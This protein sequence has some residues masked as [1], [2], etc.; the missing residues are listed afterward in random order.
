MEASADLIEKFRFLGVTEPEGWAASQEGEGIPQL[1]RAT[2]LVELA[3]IIGDTTK[4]CLAGPYPSTRL[5]STVDAIRSAGVKDDDI[6]VLLQFA[7]TSVLFNVSA[8]LS[9]ASEIHRNPDGVSVSLA[10]SHDDPAVEDMTF[11][12]TD[13]ALHESLGDVVTARLGKDVFWN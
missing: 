10:I 9:G 7:A 5:T 1:T 8:L 4:D 2:I 13:L 11:E 3:R 12:P 6:V